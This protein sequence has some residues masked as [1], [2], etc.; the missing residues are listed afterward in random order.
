M[1]LLLRCA[2]ASTLFAPSAVEVI[3]GLLRPALEQPLTPNSLKALATLIVFFPQKTAAIAPELP[4][5]AYA[6]QAV[7]L[8]LQVRHNSFWDRLWLCFLSRLAKWDT[9]VRPCLLRSYPSNLTYLN[10][11]LPPTN[12]IPFKVITITLCDRLEWNNTVKHVRM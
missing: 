9:H 5:H 10:P 7:D 2:Q 6:E 8:W 11:S 1:D 12:V 3:W 4:W